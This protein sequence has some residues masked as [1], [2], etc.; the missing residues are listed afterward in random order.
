[1]IPAGATPAQLQDAARDVDSRA[2]RFEETVDR[3]PMFLGRPTPERVGER[4]VGKFTDIR[5]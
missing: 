1:M 3:L 2:I 4:H 5:N